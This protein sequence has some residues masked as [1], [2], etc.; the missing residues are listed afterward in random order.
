MY[1]I[2]I[3]TDY[4]GTLAENGAVAPSTLDGLVRFKQSGRKLVMVTGRELPHLERVFS[5]LDLFDRVVAENGALLYNP[6]TK[7]E[8]PLASEPP[9]AFV[10]RLKDAGVAPL[11]VG[12]SIVATWEPYEKIVLDAI[13]DL[14]LELQI[15]FNKGAVMVLPAGINKASGLKAALDDLGLSFH[16]VVAVGDA[17]NDHAFMQASG[18]AVAVANAL[19]AVKETADLVTSGAR[20]AGVEELID[21]VVESDVA[22]FAKVGE[23]G[24][25]E[26]G[27]GPDRR[28]IAIHPY[29]GG[30]LIAGLSGSGKSTLATA[31]IE[32][33]IAAAFQVCVFDPEGDYTQL[34]G[35]IMLGDSKSPPHLQA[36]LTALQRPSDSV[37]VT[38][39]AISPEDRPT[40]FSRFVAALTELRAR[41]G[42]PHWLILD[43]AHNL[44]P[45]ER[46]ASA[47]ALP[48]TLPAT[49]FVTVDPNALHQD[50]L[51]RVDDV[52]AIGEKAAGTV[53][54]FCKA[55]KITAPRPPALAPGEGQALLWRRCAGEKPIL[56]STNPPDEK[57]ER[58][59]R[60][61]VEGEL[62]EDKSFFFRGPANAL[63]L[64]AQN[65]TLFL[66]IA[67]GVDDETWSHHLD[68]HD[69]SRWIREAIKDEE[70]AEEV[71][72]AEK[73][74]AGP[75]ETR[76]RVRKA[77]ERRYIAP[78]AAQ[79]AAG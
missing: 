18:F 8:Q 25:V 64:R 26:I 34:R 27:V 79:N 78:V 40:A 75:R 31:L 53:A 71:R 54:S 14:G 33:C 24:A 16:N 22:A 70:L 50:A 37:V 57:A 52:F 60:K 5:R 32:R 29:G 21:A 49:V 1:I 41:T 9:E 28:P 74:E 12:R 55:L 73:D 72:Q 42:R 69:Y 66:Q 39:A 46:N 38:L 76:R 77:I 19:P 36:V 6:A 65:L 59:T 67:D 44:L 58:H 2:C 17:E 61:Y 7:K 68:A 4:D 23:H 45:A 47:T 62:D 35:A 56:M 13:Q 30:A 63:N 43:E 15:I 20:G 48:P 10:K 3:A 11:S 51:E